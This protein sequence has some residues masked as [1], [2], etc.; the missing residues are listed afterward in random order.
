[1]ACH[2]AIIYSYCL[3]TST[4]TEYRRVGDLLIEFNKTD[5]TVFDTDINVHLK[6]VREGNYGW[7]GMLSKIKKIIILR[8]SLDNLNLTTL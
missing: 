1:M 5:P 6:K 2:G 7:I 3:Q 4:R 8:Y